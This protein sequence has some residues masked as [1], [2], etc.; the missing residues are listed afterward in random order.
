MII[1]CVKKMVVK[2]EVIRLMVSVMVK[3]LIGFEFRKNI[4]MV[5]MN[6]VMLV[7][8]M[9]DMVFL[10]LLLMVL[11]ICFLCCNFLWMCL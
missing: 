7:L 5:V 8:M 6:E 1:N 3:F 4:I 10:K 2:I 11:I 9:V